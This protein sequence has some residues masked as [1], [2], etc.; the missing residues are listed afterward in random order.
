MA[1]GNRAPM[2]VLGYITPW[3]PQRP[4]LMPHAWTADDSFDF[5]AAQH[6]HARAMN[7]LRSPVYAD[8]FAPASPQPREYV[9]RYHDS[10]TRA[11]GWPGTESSEFKDG[12]SSDRPPMPSEDVLGNINARPQLTQQDLPPLRH[13]MASPSTQ[14]IDLTADDES[15]SEVSQKQVVSEDGAKAHHSLGEQS[16]MTFGKIVKSVG[17][18]RVR[19]ERDSEDDNLAVTTPS[20]RPAKRVRATS[21]DSH[22]VGTKSLDELPSSKVSALDHNDKESTPSLEPVIEQNANNQK[23]LG[24]EP[25]VP[26]P[27]SAI[28]RPPSPLTYKDSKKRSHIESFGSQPDLSEEYPAP[29]K[30]PKAESE[31]PPEA[32]T[33][34]RSSETPRDDHIA[35]NNEATGNTGWTK[36]VYQTTETVIDKSNEDQALT[37]KAATSDIEAQRLVDVK[38]TRPASRRGSDDETATKFIAAPKKRRHNREDSD[39]EFEPEQR[40]KR[41]KTNDQPIK[42]ANKSREH[43]A[44]KARSRVTKKKFNG[45][46]KTTKEEHT[47]DHRRLDYFNHDVEPAFPPPVNEYVNFEDISDELVKA[48]LLK[49]NSGM[50]ITTPIHDQFFRAIKD[51]VLDAAE[52]NID[53][54]WFMHNFVAMFM[55]DRVL[56]DRREGGYQRATYKALKCLRRARWN[57]EMAKVYWGTCD[58]MPIV[59]PGRDQNYQEFK[60]KLAAKR[61]AGEVLVASEYWLCKKEAGEPMPDLRTIEGDVWAVVAAWEGTEREDWGEGAIRLTPASLGQRCADSD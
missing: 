50:E 49:V 47:K 57:V 25:A 24:Q 17:Q 27:G 36:Y 52:G 28:D 39:S 61:Q 10:S 7:R 40:R 53:Q 58:Y 60:E 30:R 4:T 35:D 3:R 31:D 44:Q 2:D 6:V 46:V 56:I 19:D 33:I 38:T 34:S 11:S 13:E 43:P 26:E 45:V 37:E 29:Y 12:N 23:L 5:L 8:G 59:D 1:Q 15:S 9:R 42:T 20:A 54:A 14:I 48:Y 41:R 22:R 51:L 16:V 18:K 32:D 21:T 55:N